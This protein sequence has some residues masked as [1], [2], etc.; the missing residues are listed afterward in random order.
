M[1]KANQ[2][3]TLTYKVRFAIVTNLCY[4]PLNVTEIHEIFEF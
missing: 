3:D 1:L 2:A 4:L